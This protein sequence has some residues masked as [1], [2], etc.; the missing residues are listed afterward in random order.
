IIFTIYREARKKGGIVFFDEC[1]DLF[2]ED[3]PESRALLNEIENHPVVTILITNN[4]EKLDPALSRR[5]MKKV[6]FSLPDYEHRKEIWEVHI[7]DTV[8]VAEPQAIAELA[9]KY[10]FSGGQIRNSVQMA[11]SLSFNDSNGSEKVILSSEVL[12]HAAEAQSVGLIVPQEDSLFMDDNVENLEFFSTDEKG[13][14]EKIRSILQN[15]SP[16]E[17]RLALF[18][19]KIG[20]NNTSL[21]VLITCQSFY[22]G[23]KAASYILKDVN[24]KIT[25]KHIKSILNE[26]LNEKEEILY[27]RRRRG[28][29]ASVFDAI[30]PVESVLV[31]GDDENTIENAINENNNVSQ[32][33]LDLE[34][35]LANISSPV[36]YITSATR[37]PKAISSRW[38]HYRINL[39]DESPQEREIIWKQFLSV[40]GID[41]GVAD[42]IY[43]EICSLENDHFKNLLN[44]LCFEVQSRKEQITASDIKNITNMILDKNS[45]SRQLFGR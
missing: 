31:I 32:M 9:K 42:D 12:E 17:E 1:D 27:P 35:H 26:I 43:P 10:R 11:V 45:N 5:I 29:H 30:K 25:C 38:F 33:W 7:P 24:Q 6:R 28:K 44:T 14:I 18:L 16:P 4:P 2:Q 22:R 21:K 15:Y 13:R 3:S 36:I 23:V 41:N 8:Q 19:N 40:L 39:Q 37:I 34:R 20:S